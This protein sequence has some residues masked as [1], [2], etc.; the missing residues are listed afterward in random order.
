MGKT[1]ARLRR[2]THTRGQRRLENLL[3]AAGIEIN[4]DR[5]YDIKILD[6]RIFGLALT[7]GVEGLLDAYV[8]G[9][10]ETDRL[11][12]LTA[13]LL[14][15]QVSMPE[16][17]RISHLLT[18]IAARLLNLQNRHRSWR[19][20]RHYNLGNDVFQATLDPYMQYTCGYWKDASD[21][22][23]AQEAKLDLIAR[24]LS[25][26]PGLRVLDIGCGWGGFAKFVAERYGVSVVGITI[27]KEQHEMAKSTCEGLPVEVRLQD[28]RDLDDS[29]FDAI[30][31]VGMIEHVGFKNYRGFMETVR[32]SLKPE[33]LFLLQTIG[34]NV[35]TVSG[36][37]WVERHIFPDGML[38]SA[39]QLST[40]AED[41]MVIEDW[42]NFGAHYEK[43]L[44]AW[45]Q[46]FESNWY[47]LR[48]KYG[49]N[50]YRMWKCYLLIFAGAFR[51]R[52]VQLWQ[53]VFS[54]L[55]VQGGYQSVR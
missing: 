42:H 16:A 5:P 55:G 22:N 52:H 30:T 6:D 25:L 2:N 14:S 12:E 21:L 20:L 28:Y 29:P 34:G 32:R 38:P 27:S 18:N 31:T 54:P 4:G 51:A 8:E 10:W 44:L 24:K 50:F 9:W 15:S 23:K 39:K 49:N 19:I 3:S 11:D 47:K 43:T 35:S 17:G 13:K 48:D 1:L 33:G 41:L 26:R 36:N 45:L 46:N 37:A 53:I 7:G 40:A